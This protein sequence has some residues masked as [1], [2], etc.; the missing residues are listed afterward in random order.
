MKKRVLLLLLIVLLLVSVTGCGSDSSSKSNGEVNV[1]NWGEY[2][3][4]SLLDDFEEE[5]GIAVNYK[6]FETNEQLYAVLK[7]G[8]SSYDVIIP[9]DYMI[10]RLVGEDMLEELNF[11]N[12]PNFE[13]LSDQY[14]G[15]EFDPFNEYS[16]PYTSG[17]VGIIYDTK[18]VTEEVTSWSIL[19]DEKYSDQ[20]LMFDN[21]RDAMGIALK[22]LGYSLNTTDE[23]ELR[24]GY[25]L[26]KKQGDILQA[27]VMDQIFDKLESGEAAIG[28]YYAGDYLT[29]LEGNS[30]LAFVLPEEGANWFVDSMCIPKGAENKENAEAFINYMCSTDV[31]LAN[32]EYL[33]YTSPNGEVKDLIKL[34]DTARSIIY[35][36]EEILSRCEVFLNLPTETLD[37]YDELWISLKS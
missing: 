34:D 13:L 14:L 10:G 35:P 36:S 11:D 9:S 5:T 18:V 19:F 26:L 15:L 31:S 20:I 7:A 24:E 16:V 8:G 27:Y 4:E 3:D 2:I 29:M 32:A 37:L 25:G 1:Y 6:T 17:T 23:N 21:S 33:G 30:D 22:Y 28:P 12:I